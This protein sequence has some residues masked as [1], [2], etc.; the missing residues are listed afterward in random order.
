MGASPYHYFVPVQQNVQAA[1]DALRER[2][3]RAGRYNP[4]MRFPPFGDAAA[5][6]TRRPLH[7]SIEDA[8]DDAAEDG[9][10]SILDIARI[11]PTR[12]LGVAAPLSPA[13]CM[14]FFGTLR[15]TRQQVLESHELY[16]SVQRGTCIYATIY[17]WDV[18]TELFFLGYSFD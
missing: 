17:E 1:L 3:L 10:R 12:S 14:A 15:P 7:A 11:G 6:K 5:A 13:E 8:Q 4:V 2:E 16:E 18:A 9:T